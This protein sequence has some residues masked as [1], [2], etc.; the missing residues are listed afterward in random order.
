MDPLQTAHTL[1]DFL[2]N[3]ETD[4]FQ[5]A[6]RF[7]QGFPKLKAAYNFR[8]LEKMKPSQRQELWEALRAD[9]EPLIQQ[10]RLGTQEVCMMGEALPGDPN[11]RV[12]KLEA[13]R[14]AKQRLIE[15]LHAEMEGI[16]DATH[17]AQMQ[18]LAR[19][20]AETLA[21]RFQE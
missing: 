13:M 4:R 5:K 20:R 21:A 6:M 11:E 10:A 1:L 15:Q 12:A 17:A 19:E 9:V 18:I 16:D 2:E 7:A 8:S 3:V 14:A